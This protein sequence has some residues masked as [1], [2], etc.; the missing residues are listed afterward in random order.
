MRQVWTGGDVVPPSAV[1]AALSGPDA[2]TVVNGYGPTETTVFATRLPLT[3]IGPGHGS[4]PIGR[5]LDG[6]RILLLDDALRP[7]PPGTAGE[8]YL[9]GAGVG[10]GYLRRPGLTAERFVADPSGPPGSRMYR[11]GDL[12]RWNTDGT[13]DFAG[14]SDTQVKL[15]GFRIETSEVDAVL[16]AEPGVRQ[17]LTVLREDRPGDRRLVSYVVPAQDAD[18][19]AARL[20]DRLPA[21]MVPAAIIALDELPLTRNGKVDRAALP[22]PGG[23]ADPPPG[24]KPAT[25]AEETVAAL[26]R[27]VLGLAEVPVDRSFFRLGGDSIKA[28]QL[29]GR[30]RRAG[31]DLSTPEI[32]RT[33]TV[34]E[35]ARTLQIQPARR[36][37]PEDPRAED[38]LVPLTPIMHWLRGQGGA[39]AGF[40]Q[41]LRVRVPAGVTEEM[42][43]T[44]VQALVDRHPML[45]LSVS[46]VD[47]I[48]SAEI[49]PDTEAGFTR[50]DAGDPD[51][52]DHEQRAR[53][54]LDPTRGRV[55]EAVWFD[56]GS[57]RPGALTLAVHHLVVDGVSW[58]IL[59]DDLRE[60][61]SAAREGRPPLPAP[62]GT[63]FAHWARLLAER[64]QHPSVTGHYRRWKTAAPTHDIAMSKR[65]LDPSTDTEATRRVQVLTLP[66]AVSGLLAGRT[67][68]AFGCSLNDLLLTAFALAVVDRRTEA[69]TAVLV[70]LEGHGREEFAEGLD[71]T[72]T[73]G[74]FTTLFPTV[75]DP[76]VRWREARDEPALLDEA[77][78]RVRGTMGAIPDNGLGYGLLRHLNPQTAPS[79]ATGRVPQLAFNFLGRFET[80]EE[81]DWAAVPGD[82]VL[83]SSMPEELA[84]AHCIEL[85]TLLVEQAEGPLLQANWSWAGEVLD[86][87]DV[88][89]L[90][91]RWFEV[92]TALTERAAD[93]ATASVLPLPPLAQGLLFHSLYDH[94]G[95]DPYLVQFVFT[96]R[97]ELDTAAMRGALHALLRRHPQLSAGIQHSSSGRPVQVVPPEFTVPWTEHE[98]SSERDVDR[99]LDTDRRERFELGKPPLVRAAVLRRGTDRHVFVLTTHHLLL[100]GWS[101]PILIRELFALYAG[102]A[103]PEAPSYRDFL[104]WLG[105][106]DPE[107]DQA[108][109]RDL[110]SDVDGPTLVAGRDRP[111]SGA[112]RGR[113]FFELGAQSSAR[114]RDAAAEGDLTVSVLVRLAWATVLGSLTGRDDVLFGATVSGRPPELAGAENMVGLLINTVPVRVRL[115]PARTITETLHALR[116]QHLTTLEHQHADLTGLQEL[117]GHRELFDTAIV[118]ENYPLD[119]DALRCPAPGLEIT[120]LRGLDGSHYPLA[121]LVL[122]GERFGLRLDHDEDLFDHA[123]AH[124]LLARFATILDRIA[125]EPRARLA[126]LDLLLHDERPGTAAEP[127][128]TETTL[129]GLFAAQVARRPEATAV[130]DGE[131]RLSY[132]ELDEH[133]TR[134]AALLR[135]R[136]AGPERLVALAL[137]RSADAVIGVLAVLKS[138]A[139]YVP[140]DLEHPAQRLNEILED[141]G[142]VLVVTTEDAAVPGGR[143]KLLLDDVAGSVP[144]DGVAEISVSAANTAYVIHTSGSTGRPKGVT[145]SHRTVVNLLS[146]TD[147]LI[148]AGPEDVHSLFH[149]LAFDVSVWEMWAALGRGGRLVVV[150]STV[151]RSPRELL[152]LL[153]AEGVTVLSQTPSAFYQL[154][155]AEA[156]RPA[157]L[158]LRMVIFA[159][160]ALDPTRIRSWQGPGR[161][162]LVNLYGITETTVHSTFQEISDPGTTRSV[163]G[164]ALPGEQIRLLDHALRPVPPGCPGE[165][166][167]AGH[168]VTR[169]YL[170]RPGLTAQRFVADLFGGPGARMYRS[171]DLARTL[172]DG[173]LEYLGRTDHQVKV[174]GFRI[175][176]GEVE[177]RLEK[178]PAVHRAV[179]LPHEQDRLVAY[180]VLRGPVGSGELRAHAAAALPAHMVPAFVVPV[181]EIPLT[182]NGKLDRRALPDPAPAPSVSRPADT[183]EERI[184]CAAF[185]E[186]LGVAEAGADDSFFDLGGH[187]L[188]ATRLINLIRSRTGIELGIR[189]LFDAPTPAALAARLSGPGSRRRPALR[190]GARPD[191]VPLSAAQRRLWFFTEFAGPNAVYNMPFSARL[192]GELSVKALREAVSD[193][194]T[195]HESLRTRVADVDGEPCQDLR[196]AA[197]A[198]FAVV[199]TTRADLPDRLAEAGAHRFDL[200]AELPVHVRLF[201]LGPDEHVLLFLVH[202]IAA[203]GWSFAPLVADLS[204]AYRARLAG[205]AP[206]WTDEPIQYADFTL[207]QNELDLASDEEFWRETLRG[208]PQAP[209]SLPTDHPRPAVSAHRGETISVDFDAGLHTALTGLA[210]AHGVSLFMLLH[211]ALATLTSR[212]GAGGDLAIGTPVAGRHD[213]ALDRAIGCFVN[214]V[215]LRSTIDPATPFTEFLSTVRDTDLAAFAHQDLQ[216]DRLVELLNP[217]RTPGSHPLFQIML[218]FQDTPAIRFDLPGIDAEHLPV[219]G[220]GSRLDLL[221]S[222]WQRDGGGITGVLEYDAELFRP[223]TARALTTRFEQLLRAITRAPDTAI[224]DLDILLPGERRRVLETWNDTAAT[225]PS[226]TVAEQFAAHVAA[227]PEAP[228]ILSGGGTTSYR[229][230][231]DLVRGIAADLA[232]Q[233]IGP[234]DLVALQ[235][236][237][238]PALPAA[239]LAVHSLGAAYLPCDR[240]LPEQ[241]LATLLT[242][243]RP[244]LLLRDEEGTIEF[245][246]PGGRPS[247]LPADSAYTIYTSGSTGKP[248]GVL[249]GH[250]ALA[251]LLGALGEQLAVTPSDRMLACSPTGFDMSVPEFFLPLVSGAAMVLVDRDVSR[252]PVLLLETVQRL[253]VT[254]LQT[255]PSLWQALA[256]L[257][258]RLPGVRAVIG[259]EAVPDSL[260]ES[261][262][263]LGC[264]LL[265]CYGPTETTVWSA[266]LPVG[267]RTEATVP[268][269]RPLA[270][271]RCVVL[272]AHLHPVPP[273]VLGHLYIA[274]DGVATGYLNQS[275]QTAQRFVAD[276]FGGPGARMYH[277][278][279]LASWS[280]QGIL[281]FHGR[282]DRQLKL[283]G[284]RIE[285]GEI[286]AALTGHPGVTAAA[287]T[288]H[289]HGPG[290]HRLVGYLIGDAEI[291]AVHEYVRRRLPSYMRPSK[292]LTVDEF[293]L[294]HNGKLQLDHL[295]A[296]RWDI[297][298]E[299]EPPRNPREQVLCSLFAEVLGLPRVGASDNF[300]ELGGHS[301]LAIR[302]AARIGAVLG[303][304]PQIRDVFLAGTPA[305][306]AAALDGTGRTGQLVPFRAGGDGTPVFC[307]PPLSGIS[308]LYAGLLHHL[309]RAHPL[310]G[311]QDD[312]PGEELRLPR[313]VDEMADRYADLLSSAHPT[314]PVHLVGWSFGGVVA[315]AMARLLR[316]RGRE[317][318]LLLLDP[319]AGP[320][321]DLLGEPD[322]ERIHRVLLTAVGH[323]DSVFAP[324]ELTAKALFTILR[325]ENSFFARYTEDDIRRIVR[326][327][328]NNAALLRGHRPAHYAGDA[329]LVTTPGTGDS[330]VDWGVHVGGDLTTHEIDTAHHRLLQPRNLSRLGDILRRQ[331]GAAG[332]PEETP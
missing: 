119:A 326:V 304:D 7:V 299:P 81:R 158:A 92:L 104:K 298:A 157:E 195:R 297:A 260:A 129:P 296:P 68:E 28:I 308:W 10:Q 151:T 64:A 281:H 240:D 233:G 72:R 162:R 203:D 315:H 54:V 86:T 303:V 301:V 126:E 237:R 185:A 199:A 153:A 128:V 32:F 231:D 137:P 317:V 25:A 23:H 278:G 160:E 311:F 17:S 62:A 314:G 133:S 266:T 294:S 35:L 291:D 320:A 67:A 61:G 66:P 165:I 172:P 155:A 21:F 189:A 140:L 88:L 244:A 50:V 276:P 257:Q 328:R 105:A 186:T 49:R 34:S 15:R 82:T 136:G 284:H 225:P 302:L 42:L 36:P 191:R 84:M 174:R 194:L 22:A 238:G 245:V 292:L 280:S 309:D 318:G 73:V 11:T 2:P 201:V 111:G 101:M 94:D 267:D 307:V 148:G 208:L 275:A 265:A 122:P 218:A 57:D 254:V 38:P 232:S 164:T 31:L 270:N 295:P 9:A 161:P 207:W 110:L 24:P 230:L 8:I 211:A 114:I 71:L 45:R 310:Y 116:E 256:D 273:G 78:E 223:A 100:D 75:L 325:A 16:T 106:R 287:V 217:V 83:G 196:P 127:A 243:S 170:G 330:T 190:P 251:N 109:W 40:S 175:E 56:A 300:F 312:V 214:T 5:P 147:E 259:G 46:I 85:N 319:Q 3:A 152:G 131:R 96:L 19:L 215:V 213:H 29:A 12:A 192:T 87:E 322:D 44:I 39:L 268:L 37:T 118:F 70:D 30:A 262:R 313:S 206:Q 253:G 65:A 171:G 53:A 178:H 274:G 197:E 47:G 305:R 132:R 255:T 321:Q 324:G 177:R 142:P 103:L 332:R 182:A 59:L 102:A 331:L 246:R 184:L 179:V 200:G 272:D 135:A 90:G 97:G 139:G 216:F 93:L 227:T 27:D 99:F 283:R 202:H 163:V 6:K 285:P 141:T 293:P 258:P 144:E 323:D 204:A 222:L 112:V 229:Q 290:D 250:P 1:R 183:E 286:E 115:D 55:V 4:V 219:R 98:V 224:A 69:G 279:D 180:A 252:D 220:G 60:I 18:R 187:S 228:A 26:F 168:G 121:L 43:R 33:P 63:S 52:G 123:A 329:T 76:G 134:L 316:E 14:R 235:L 117:A 288:V 306:L 143:P 327:S 181:P 154:M 210:K 80:A 124:R 167:V 95:T 74:W 120:G 159:G 48:W 282:S 209:S 221:W 41:S 263:G 289:E 248:K 89:S 234:G 205:G 226:A 156:E 51:A 58:R 166:Y 176:P 247:L 13:L 188:L 20:A 77:V 107:A 198:D 79:L 150:P 241:R 271:T 212:L 146:S 173:T 149:S 138:G 130:V 113:A 261:V 145:V 269:G 236:A 242:D 91:H 277:T 249:I 239:M 169:G 193:L 264:S 108:A 125:S